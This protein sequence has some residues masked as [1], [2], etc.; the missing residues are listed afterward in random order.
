[1]SLQIYYPLL[2]LAVIGAGGCVTGSNPALT[3][4]ELIHHFQITSTK[5]IIAHV[6]SLAIVTEAARKCQISETRIF[7]LDSPNQQRADGFQSWHSLLSHGEA[8]WQVLGDQYGKTSRSVALVASTSGTTGL[9]KAAEIS[10]GALVAQCEMIRVFNNRSIPVG[11]FKTS[12]PICISDSSP[13]LSAHL[14]TSL[15]RLCWS[16][17]SNS[18]STLGIDDLLS[19]KVP[20]R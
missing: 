5:Y 2:W 9:P 7:V 4:E 8:D 6:D 3:S 13:D 15:S 10:H 1:M 19:S 20:A 14:P 11:L 12:I 17:W 16:A 18:S